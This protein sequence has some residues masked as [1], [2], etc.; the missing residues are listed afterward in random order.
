MNIDGADADTESIQ[1]VFPPHDWECNRS[2]Q[3]DI[4]LRGIDRE[5]PPVVCIDLHESADGLLEP[6]IE[7]IA[8]AG[9]KRILTDCA[10]DIRQ[11]RRAGETG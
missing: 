1:L 5:L 7:L 3:E 6:H 11:S 8:P 9:W 2:V 10:E 4:E